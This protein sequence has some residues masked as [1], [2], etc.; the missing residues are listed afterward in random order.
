MFD[1]QT[2]AIHQSLYNNNCDKFP[3][4]KKNSDSKTL[5]NVLN[6]NV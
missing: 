4:E 1:Y 5:F 3:E 6:I 2:N